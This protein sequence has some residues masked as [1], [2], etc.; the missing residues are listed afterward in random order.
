MN[1]AGASQRVEHLDDGNRIQPP[2]PD[3]TI[4]LGR[5]RGSVEYAMRR[6]DFRQGASRGDEEVYGTVAEIEYQVL[7][8]PQVSLLARYDNLVRDSIFQAPVGFRVE[9]LTLGVNVAM[10]GGS[11]LMFNYER[12]Q[13]PDPTNDV[14]DLIGVRWVA[15]F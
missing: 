12:W 2:G 9:R 13:F 6:S 15:T 14:N 4:R 7:D 11:L 10:P 8:C 1:H 5:W 3:A